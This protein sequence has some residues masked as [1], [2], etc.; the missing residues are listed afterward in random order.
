LPAALVAGVVAVPSAG[1]AG[2]GGHLV[3]ARPDGKVLAI[4]FNSAAP[5]ALKPDTF[6]LDEKGNVKDDL[7]RHG[8]LAAGVPGVLAGLQRA[9]DTFGTRSFAE[10]V[11]PAIR[12]ARDGFP[13]SKN[14]AAAIKGARARLAKDPG[15]AKLFFVKGEPLA[16]GATSR[17]P[18]LADLL[19][20]LADRGGVGTFY[21]GDVAKMEIISGVP[22]VRGQFPG[23]SAARFLWRKS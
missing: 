8:W 11:K 14:F 15:S 2:Y 20:T 16:E 23:A 3:V 7:N 6:S 1:I 5:A 9:L 21:K 19:Q 10:V 13:V 17:N 12:F 18:D 22:A 4:D